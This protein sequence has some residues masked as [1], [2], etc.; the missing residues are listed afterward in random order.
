M[1]STSRREL[2]VLQKVAIWLFTNAAVALLLPLLS[3]LSV[4]VRVA[5]AGIIVLVSGVLFFGRAG[6]SVIALAWSWFVRT[7]EPVALLLWLVPLGA[8]LV[9][10][11]GIPEHSR[12]YLDD[13][14]TALGLCS[15]AC[16]EVLD[17]TAEWL[18]LAKQQHSSSRAEIGAMIRS[19]GSRNG[20]IN[21]A[22]EGTH[23]NYRPDRAGAWPSNFDSLS[24]VDKLVTALTARTHGLAELCATINADA[25]ANMRQKRAAVGP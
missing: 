5:I 22:C 1:S 20:H 6:A 11:H 21:E 14:F 23:R 25:D 9:V 12:K 19:F 18:D 10:V 24:E 2:T 16:E 17:E 8:V 13:E 15:M 4:G 7:G 3:Q